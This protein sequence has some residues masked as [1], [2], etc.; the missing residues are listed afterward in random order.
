MI[1]TIHLKDINE[2]YTFEIREDDLIVIETASEV[3]EIDMKGNFI[4]TI[5]NEPVG[6]INSTSEFV[7]TD[8]IIYMVK[9][10]IGRER[11]VRYIKGEE[12]MIYQ[13]PLNAYIFK[14]ARIAFSFFVLAM[15]IVML[16]K[17]FIKSYGKFP[18]NPK[19]WINECRELIKGIKN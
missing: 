7:S 9:S 12:V 2:E 16:R 13:L 18:I 17:I 8:G 5:S 19:A 15:I 11:V 6:D 3:Y 14:I 4:R 1:R 10:N